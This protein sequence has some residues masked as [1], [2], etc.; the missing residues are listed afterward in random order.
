MRSVSFSRVFHSQGQITAVNG[1]CNAVWAYDRKNGQASSYVDSISR[2]FTVVAG[3][4][5]SERG[6][7]AREQRKNDGWAGE[8]QMLVPHMTTGDSVIFN[9]AYY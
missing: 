3:N 4:G 8:D 6:P 2:L 9:G 5:L 1:N 7:R